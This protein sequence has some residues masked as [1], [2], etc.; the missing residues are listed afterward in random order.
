MKFDQNKSDIT[1]GFK[2]ILHIVGQPTN[3]VLRVWKK[4]HRKQS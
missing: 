1:Q 2:H 3:I 4:Y